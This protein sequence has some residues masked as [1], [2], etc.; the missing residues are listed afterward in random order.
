M[1][2]VTNAI[3]DDPECQAVFTKNH[4]ELIDDLFNLTSVDSDKLISELCYMIDNILQS[5]HIKTFLFNPVQVIL[6]KAASVTNSRVNSM[7]NSRRTSLVNSRRTSFSTFKGSEGRRLTVPKMEEI[8]KIEDST[9]SAPA[10][11]ISFLETLSIVIAQ[12]PFRIGKSGEDSIEYHALKN[13]MK[14]FKL[15]RRQVTA[16]V[17]GKKKE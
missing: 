10:K 14:L 1:W 13:M 2:T 4:E 15:N 7:V 9:D 17:I 16:H 5:K 3:A 11:F 12:K 6:F 8:L